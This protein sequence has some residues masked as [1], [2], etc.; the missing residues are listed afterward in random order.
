MSF[1]FRF[2]KVSFPTLSIIPPLHKI[3]MSLIPTNNAT[4]PSS[5]RRS[6]VLWEND[7]IQALINERRRRNFDFHYMYPGRSRVRFWQEV[8]NAVNGTCRTNYTGDQCRR[9]FTSLITEYG[10]SKNK[11]MICV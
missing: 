2:I 5:S 9:K 1:Q 8:A 10:V 11:H 3:K 4:R 7:H 6:R